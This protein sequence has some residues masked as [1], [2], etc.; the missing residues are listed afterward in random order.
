MLS[1]MRSTIAGVGGALRGPIVGIEAALSAGAFD[2][3]VE[4]EHVRPRGEAGY[5]YAWTEL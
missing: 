2:A 3:Y 5:T 1:R 4:A